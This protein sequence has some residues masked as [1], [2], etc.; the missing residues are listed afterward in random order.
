MKT[1]KLTIAIG[2]A[3]IGVA[4]ITASAFAYMGTAGVNSPYGTYANGAYGTYPNGVVGGHMGGM[5]GGYQYGY[6]AQ[7]NSATPTTPAYPYQYRIGG[8]HG[9]LGWNGYAAP[10]YPNTGTTTTPIT[11]E[12]AVTIAQQYLTRLNN[13][14]LAV[15][16]VEEYTQNFYVQVYE[17]NTGIG[18][19]ELLIDKYTGRIYPEMGPNMIWNTKYGMHSGMM[20]WFTGN[21]ATPMTVTAEQAETNAQQWLNANLPGTTVDEAEP[22]CGYYHVMVLSAGKGYG[23][24][25]VNGYTG[26][27][28]YHTWHGTFIQELEL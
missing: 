8:C 11:I 14:D 26:H 7:P 3:V 6:P 5:M 21:P 23:M 1:W 28:W 13:P 20:G 10:A 17:K 16:E 4:L 2:L 24:L 15:R 12:T 25:S 22:F 27:V 18:A 9:R 19:V